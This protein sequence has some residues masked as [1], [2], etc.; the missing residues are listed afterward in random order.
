MAA[1]LAAIAVVTGAIVVAAAVAVA[2]TV[3][4]QITKYMRKTNSNDFILIYPVKC[5]NALFNV[6]FYNGR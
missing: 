1:E 2:T 6:P 3:Q 5:R 4:P